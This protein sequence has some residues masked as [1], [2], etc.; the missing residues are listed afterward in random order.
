[1]IFLGRR[2]RGLIIFLG[3]RFVYFSGLVF[4]SGFDDFFML[5]VLVEDRDFVCILHVYLLKNARKEKKF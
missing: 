4:S 5:E 3:Q 2:F 1:M